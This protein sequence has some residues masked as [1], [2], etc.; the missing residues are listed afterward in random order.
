MWIRPAFF[1]RWHSLDSMDP[2]SN[3]NSL[4]TPS[5]FILITPSSKTSSFQFLISAY[6][7]YILNKSEDQILAS[8]PP[9]P[10]RISIIIDLKFSVASIFQLVVA[11]Q[12]L[13]SFWSSSFWS[14]VSASA[15]KSVPKELW[16]H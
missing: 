2:V 12:K 5:P 6:L 1:S 15:F 8:S 16:F 9:T 7:E 10:W 3:L 14:S 4:K 11:W 13:N